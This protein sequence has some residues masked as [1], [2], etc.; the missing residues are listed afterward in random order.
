MPGR[1]W[2]GRGGD[3]SV[4]CHS[5]MPASVSGERGISWTQRCSRWVVGEREVSASRHSAN[6]VLEGTPVVLCPPLVSQVSNLN[7]GTQAS[8][9]ERMG[10]VASDW[11]A[12][13]LVKYMYSHSRAGGTKKRC[14][15]LI[16]TQLSPFPQGKG[17][18]KPPTALHSL[19]SS[20]RKH[21]PALNPS[22]RG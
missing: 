19:A 15:S 11:P 6:R 7:V 9:R 18:E 8:E 20:K 1:F 2:S 4:L 3:R 13:E 16:L 12:G 14:A 10:L 5:Q 21:L 17:A 22:P